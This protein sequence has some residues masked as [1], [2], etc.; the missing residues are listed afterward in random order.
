MA[1]TSEPVVV[2]FQQ[3][4]KALTKQEAVGN[5]REAAEADTDVTDLERGR[6][7]AAMGGILNDLRKA[8][9][10]AGATVLTTAH[11]GAASRLQ[12]L[13]ASGENADLAFEPL[14]T[15]GFEAKFD[16]GDWFGWAQVAWQKLKHRTP[17]PL[18]RPSTALAEPMDEQ[19]RIAVI[20]DWGTGLY[21]APH[22]ARSIE[23]DPE[24]LSMIL[25][26]GDVYYSGTV[27][28][29]RQR[30]LGGWPD[31]TGAVNRALNSNHE[32][33]SGGVAYFTE[34]LPRF[35]QEASYFAVQNKH[36][37][38]VGLDVAYKDHAID[39]QQVDWLKAILTAAGDRKVV[40]FS[41]HQLYSHWESQG[42]KLTGH[43]GF[44]EI[45]RS[46]RI[47]AWYWGH[48]HRCSIFEEPDKEFGILARCIGHGGMPQPRGTTRYLPRVEEADFLRAVWRRSDAEEVAGNQLSS[49]VV[50][51]GPNKFIPGEEDR[52]AP[53]GYAV[54]N[55]D[56]PRLVEQVMDAEGGVIYERTLA[57]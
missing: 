57:E 35:G 37:T 27:D 25:H 54:L 4:E 55:L 52:F 47:F 29:T 45:L 34:T 21:G 46:K 38:L 16:T 32:M 53:H 20:G 9:S 19:A 13:L 50:L 30:L 42:R 33:Y 7:M 1:S 23:Q 36:W 31:R 26:L 3:I 40:L 49:V 10:D 43:S 2:T 48:E 6:V 51:D 14:P 28:E 5:L 41:H 12:S 39:D 24:P 15:G 22:I 18:I 17:H 11:N 56:G 44:G 8:E